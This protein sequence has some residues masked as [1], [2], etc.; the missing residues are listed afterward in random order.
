MAYKF[1]KAHESSYVREGIYVKPILIL[2]KVYVQMALLFPIKKIFYETLNLALLLFVHRNASNNR[3]LHL[4]Q[5]VKVS[6]PVKSYLSK[7][8]KVSGFK[9]T[10]VE[11][12][13]NCHT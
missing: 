6:H 5:I 9:C 13:R 7:S 8:L 10:V 3:L 4:K 2:K 12:V 11:K 1:I